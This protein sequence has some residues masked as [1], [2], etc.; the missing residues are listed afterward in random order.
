MAINT[1]RTY[2]ADDIAELTMLAAEAKQLD[3]DVHTVMAEAQAIIEADG[4][5]YPGWENYHPNLLPIVEATNWEKYS[6]ATAN[7]SYIP[8]VGH[9]WNSRWNP[10]TWAHRNNRTRREIA[11][12]RKAI[13]EC[14]VV[15]V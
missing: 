8:Q 2:T 14:E 13:A 4:A 12:L 7:T 15:N 9:Y 1:K 6:F 11:N 3:A 5:G 10:K